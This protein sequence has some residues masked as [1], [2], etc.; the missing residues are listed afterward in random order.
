VCHQILLQS[1]PFHDSTKKPLS[2]L[3]NDMTR[4]VATYNL[5]ADDESIVFGLQ[6]LLLN[7]NERIR[8]AALR[9]FR[10][11]IHRLIILEKFLEYRLDYLV[12]RS[13]IIDSRQPSGRDS[14]ERLES[15]KLVRRLFH[16]YPARF[17][18]SFIY[19][20]DSIINYSS[21]T[22][23]N[24]K[25]KTNVQLQQQPVIRPDQ[26][27]KC[28]LELLCEIALHNP[29]ILHECSTF[30]TML[31]Y[32]TD[33]EQEEL[34]ESV[35]YSVLHAVDRFSINDNS[36]PTVVE[37][38]DLSMQGP[39]LIFVDEGMQKRHELIKNIFS[40]LVAV[41]SLCEK[42]VL[43][44]ADRRGMTPTMHENLKFKEVDKNQQLK[45]CST[46]LKTVLRSWIG[47]TAFCQPSNSS[48]R[49]L[50]NCLLVQSE[51][52]K[53]C[54]IDLFYD[55]LNLDI[56][57]VCDNYESALSSMY[58]V[59]N[60]TNAEEGFTYVA[61]EGAC[62]LPRLSST[63]PNL[64][65]SHMALMLLTFIDA[66]FIE[67]ISEIA[68]S[69]NT[70]LAVRSTLLMANFIWLCNEHLPEEQSFLLLPLI[71]DIAI[72]DD[73]SIKRS[74]AKEAVLNINAFFEWKQRTKNTY[75]FQLAQL[76][77]H[78]HQSQFYYINEKNYSRKMSTNNVTS[79]DPLAAE[80]LDNDVRDTN[81]LQ[82]HDFRKWNWDLILA[83]L[84]DFPKQSGQVQG[85]LYERFLDKIFDFFKPEQRG[86]SDIKLTDSLS[87]ITCR[88]L[89][90]FA[91]LLVYPKSSQ[92]DIKYIA[93]NIV[94]TLLENISNA[95]YQSI[96]A[97]RDG[98]IRP[99]IGDHDLIV[100]NCVYYYLF[101]GRISGTSI[102]M[103]ALDECDIFKR[104]SEM[105]T[106][107]DEFATSVIVA[108]S[109]FN[110]YVESPCREFLLQ[111]LNSSCTALRLYATSLLRVLLRCNTKEFGQWGIDILCSKLADANQSVILEAVRILDEALEDK[112]LVY[113]FLNQWESFRFMKNEPIL[114]SYYHLA[115]G[116]LCSLR[117]KLNDL[118]HDSLLKII[119]D[120]LVYWDNYF[121]S[122]YVTLMEN[123]LFSSYSGGALL[124]N[125]Y[126]ER[127]KSSTYG[128]KRKI[129]DAHALPHL[130]RQISLNYEGFQYL[131]ENSNLERYCLD[132]K[133]NKTNCVNLAETKYIKEILWALAHV[134]S[135]DSGYQ[136]FIEKD[137]IPD[138]LRFAEECQNLSVRGTA[139][140]AIS[141]I[142]L[143]P[144]GAITLKNYGWETYRVRSH[145]LPLNNALTDSSLRRMSTRLI[146]VPSPLIP[147]TLRSLSLQ[148]TSPST[149]TNSTSSSTSTL[150]SKRPS[151]SIEIPAY[152]A[153]FLSPSTSTLT[154]DACLDSLEIKSKR[155]NT[156]PSTIL[157][158]T[159]SEKISVRHV[160]IAEES[161]V[162]PSPVTGHLPLLMD[163]NAVVCFN[164]M[165]DSDSNNQTRVVVP[166]R[167]CH[168][169]ARE[170]YTM[171]P[172]THR[173]SGIYSTGTGGTTTTNGTGSISIP[174]DDIDFSRSPSYAPYQTVPS[175]QT[176]ASE[177]LPLE[178]F[179]PRTLKAP[180]T[181]GNTESAHTDELFRS[182]LLRCNFLL[183]PDAAGYE[184]VR[185]VQKVSH[186]T[187]SQITKTKEIKPTTTK[188]TFT[189]R[190]RINSLSITADGSSFSAGNYDVTQMPILHTHHQFSSPF[191][192]RIYE[193]AEQTDSNEN[194]KFKYSELRD[195]DDA[196]EDDSTCYRGLAVPVDIRQVV[197]ISDGYNLPM[198]TWTD[199]VRS[200]TN[201]N[202]EFNRSRSS[203][204]V[205]NNSN[206][207]GE[208]APITSIP[209]TD[210]SSRVCMMC[211]NSPHDDPNISTQ[212]GF[213]EIKSLAS[214]MIAGIHIEEVEKKL[215]SWKESRP[216]I[217]DD[218]CLYS[219]ICRILSLSCVRVTAQ[220]F[221]HDLFS[222][223]QFQQFRQ[224]RLHQHSDTIEENDDEILFS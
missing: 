22:S 157:L 36:E 30:H 223:C 119:K 69:D 151:I 192:K 145:S 161:S 197:E 35:I 23:D 63:R 203:T 216:L 189:M 102:G 133:Q 31:R 79:D 54:I 182:R 105:V 117:F 44:T 202:A 86:F 115:G 198:D 166:M 1:S 111:A 78:A 126:F 178:R 82:T 171:S 66:G 56:P 208:F 93:S 218:V 20:I 207:S 53:M 188:D 222:D 80:R 87:N 163:S 32:I 28:C 160:A 122:H 186:S 134:A 8:A 34:I 83:L 64:L 41:F 116:R 170:M 51:P 179:R 150:S 90:A 149:L 55:L 108:L 120:E 75:S 43:K 138:F 62:K 164:D 17:P 16:L 204:N 5:E 176:Q 175:I 210:H 205:T 39:G 25:N 140:Y 42:G 29:Y 129:I 106:L 173:D 195:M 98:G 73:D 147:E 125:D 141:L 71:M 61:M 158:N 97:V 155:S 49:L 168:S 219:E 187:Y 196:D 132:L 142:A 154:D 37:S 7:D 59:Y 109:S 99:L 183:K 58:Q 193:H 174:F 146:T 89:L 217:F 224:R 130:Y 68:S 159:T 135:T 136:W 107:D 77:E 113:M 91:D 57:S 33:Y 26:L 46:A 165:Q 144:D 21:Q 6:L 100:T 148:I 131:R 24:R 72:A 172:Y 112:Q 162:P 185:Y 214:R 81:T 153:D 114:S 19:A 38:M 76:I 85:D 124:T 15:Y 94:R 47:F 118:K 14:R 156:V 27:V 60:L 40:E 127:R 184:Y 103:Q 11:S 137:L 65:D 101:I 167:R 2:T 92:N 221:L 48:V 177:C 220:R 201:T 123:V 45:S 212:F 110:Y 52:M 209:M 215:L 181:A 213:D 180:T 191:F 152:P 3:L 13:L 84:K 70:I 96:N 95:L 190:Q 50:V 143:T 194:S 18:I 104:L 9:A 12:V 4:Y 211:T 67:A 200:R 128:Q 199:L 74:F 206:S 139:F 10:Y 121:N 88:N 169:M